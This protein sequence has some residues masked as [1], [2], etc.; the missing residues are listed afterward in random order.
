MQ[1]FFAE[2]A[3]LEEDSD[4]IYYCA[5]RAYESVSTAG[6]DVGGVCV[7]VSVFCAVSDLLSVCLSVC[8]QAVTGTVPQLAC[9]KH[10]LRSHELP[11]LQVLHPPTH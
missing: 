8:V 3:E 5:S 10:C 11:P 7:C 6:T 4:T 2:L 1:H 9:A